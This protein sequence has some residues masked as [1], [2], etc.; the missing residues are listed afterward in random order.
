MWLWGV[1][2]ALVVGVAVMNTYTGEYWA[3]EKA[4]RRMMIDERLLA[5]ARAKL[6]AEGRLPGPMFELPANS[7]PEDAPVHLT[8]FI[9]SANDC[10]EPNAKL[11]P[12]VQE[13]YGELVSIE[14]LDMVEED[15]KRK[16]DELQLGCDAGIYFNGE[17]Q[18][19]AQPGNIVGIREF[20]GAVDTD[21]FFTCDVYGA[22]N[23]MLKEKEIEVPE[24]GEELA[25]PPP[26]LP[27]LQPPRPAPLIVRP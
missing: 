1:V 11:L 12:K 5:E 9:N 23:Y 13:V 15:V 7:G 4:E 27:A 20:M 19:K 25:E 10:L 16:S 22:I 8:V 21:R 26:G 6:E 18:R 14:Y 24:G 3:R 17:L 2:A